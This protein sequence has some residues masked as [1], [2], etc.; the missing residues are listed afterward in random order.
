MVRLRVGW[1]LGLV[2]GVSG[3]AG[4][5]RRPGMPPA[6][7]ILGATAPADARGVREAALVRRGASEPAAL[8]EPE[9]WRKPRGLS[10]FFPGLARRERSTPVPP[11]SRAAAAVAGHAPAGP[12]ELRWGRAQPEPDEDVA[13]LLSVA[14]DVAAPPAAPA[15]FS[16]SVPDDAGERLTALESVAGSAPGAPA[17]P[18]R[19]AEPDAPPPLAEATPSGART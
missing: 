11:D 2:L 17:G 14:I 18:S 5:G 8:P 1:V 12:A 6:P 9:D 4:T 13:P 15:G 19:A 3:C 7:P 10:R 16:R